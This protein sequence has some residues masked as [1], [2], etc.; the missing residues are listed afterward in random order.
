MIAACTCPCCKAA[1]ASGVPRYPKKKI[2]SSN[3]TKFREQQS[4]S[5]IVVAANVARGY[6]LA[7]QV[8]YP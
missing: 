3:P 1:S 4:R 5:K 8:V 7:L 6:S 2:A